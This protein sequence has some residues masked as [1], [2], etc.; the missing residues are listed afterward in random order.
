MAAVSRRGP[1]STVAARSVAV[2]RAGAGATGSHKETAAPSGA[3]VCSLHSAAVYLPAVN[4]VW[5]LIR[6]R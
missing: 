1:G 5:L 2:H 3:A 6:L 4:W